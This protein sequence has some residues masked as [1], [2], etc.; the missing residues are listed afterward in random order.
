MLVKPNTSHRT[1]HP[2][3]QMRVPVPPPREHRRISRSTCRPTGHARP[4]RWPTT[5]NGSGCAPCRCSSSG[6]SNGAGPTPR[7]ATQYS[8]RICRNGTSRC[9]SFSTT[10]TRRNL[11]PPPGP[12]A[13]RLAL[14]LLARTGMRA[15]ELV[16]LDADLVVCASAPTTGY[17]SRSANSAPTATSRCIR[18]Y[19]HCLPSG[20]RPTSNTS[21]P[22][23]AWSPTTAARSSATHGAASFAASAAPP[24]S[25]T[26][27]RTGCGTPWPPRPYRGM[28]L[29]AIAALLGTQENGNDLD[30][31]SHRQPGRGR[32]IRRGQRQDRRPLRP[33]TELPADYETTG[34]ARLRREAHARMLGNGLC[35]RPVELEC[36]M[37]S[38]CET[39]AYFRTSVQFLP[40][41]TRQRSRRP[42]SA[43]GVAMVEA[44]LGYAVQRGRGRGHRRCLETR[45]G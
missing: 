26:C 20:P 30:L 4:S 10:V 1:L 29:E 38:A 8:T 44:D 3:V 34:M 35:T 12:A 25:P 43:H 17:A 33:T 9:R 16:N 45:L 37:E 19:S 36:R 13:T 5:P 2:P 42:R 39:C 23:A 11:W 14:E 27:I 18:S 32:R 6:S 22:T 28:R 21:V 24:A 41:L 31:R 40:T 7:C 15:S